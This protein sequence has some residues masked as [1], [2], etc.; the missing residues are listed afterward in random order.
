VQLHDLGTVNQALSGERHQ[1][2]LIRPP[3]RQYGRPLIR[4]PQ[5]GDFQAGV[6]H[7]AVDIARHGVPDLAGDH[8]NHGL[9]E[10]GKTFTHPTQLQQSPT[11]KMHPERK[12]VSV[13]QA[14]ADLCRPPG[15]SLGLRI[16]TLDRCLHNARQQEEAPLGTLVWLLVQHPT[17][18]GEPPT[19][20][21]EIPL[22][23]K[24]E[25]HPEQA[26]GGTPNITSCDVDTMGAL[27]DLPAFVRIAEQI[28]RGCQ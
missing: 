28:G 12:Q 22:E 27:Q 18:F 5:I 24:R 6:D 14:A 13:T 21:S 15:S 16:I 7:R 23:K 11:L 19:G 10:Q 17:S 25:R 20:H 3:R 26:P 8:R 4:A 9:I 2:R 1:V